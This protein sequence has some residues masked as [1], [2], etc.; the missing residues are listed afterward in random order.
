MLPIEAV[1]TPA[2]TTAPKASSTTSRGGAVVDP[3][4]AFPVFAAS[5]SRT[6]LPPVNLA[7]VRRLNSQASLQAAGREQLQ[8]EQALAK[9]SEEDNVIRLLRETLRISDGGSSD[10]KAASGGAAAAND[11]SSSST[12]TVGQLGQDLTVTLLPY[13]L[14][15]VKWM[16]DNESSATAIKG[17]I[18]ADDMGLGKTIQV[19][20]L[21]LAHRTARRKPMLVVCM[22]STLNQWLDEITTRIAKRKAAR[23]LTYYGSGR[24][25]SKELVES[26]DIVLTTYGTLAAEFKGKGTDAKAKTAAK[27]SLLASIHWWR[28]VLDEAHLIKNKKTKTAM[29]AHQLQAEQRWCLSGTPIQNSL[30][31]LYSLLCFL[32]VPVVSDLDWWNTYIVKPSKAKATSTRE[33]ARRRLQLILQSLLLR[34]TKDQSYN[35][36]PILQLPTK[37]I[38]LRATT[39]SAD[40][41]I[42][43]DDLFN[44]AKN[45]FNKY[46]RDGTVLNNYMKV[47]ELLLRLRQACDHPALALKGKAAAPS[48]E[49]D[50][51]PICVQPLEEDAVVASKCRHRFCADC[52]ASQLA[53]GE[54]RCPTCD[55]AID[56]D[57]LLP[58]SSSPKLNGR[59]RPVA[60]EAEEHSSA[61]IEALMKALTKVREE[62]P[63]EKSIVFSQFTSFLDLVQKHMKRH[64]I[65]FVRLDGSMVQNH[66]MQAIERFNTD[67]R[68]SVMLISLKAGGTGLNL[69]VANHVFLLD[70][71]W[72][73][74]T[75]VQAIDRV[76]RLGQT[77]PVSVTQFVIKDSVEEKIIKMQ[78]RKKALAADVLSSDTN[79]KASLSRLSVSELRHLFPETHR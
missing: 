7:E 40:E 39:F 13:Q 14:D 57:K 21:Y 61:K 65:S 16:V 26:Y 64:N 38:T 67:P 56:S 73:P 58:L 46:A 6:K 62:R 66:R 35:G 72:N 28:V 43:Y 10:A 11:Q 70:P 23:V 74:F 49:E 19:I 53:S 22:L 41:R 29:A 77:R 47:L 5:T 60:E 15:G 2:T 32:H 63:G 42:V 55:V 59:E 50:V 78:E 54:S 68:V 1:T 79:K 75:E 45:T 37:T 9:E 30:D 36:R 76:H 27:P 8:R 51:C 71:W 33:K 12:T 17:G 24:S 4:F 25:Q 52:I 3:S 48:G 18:L 31:D 69:T 44:K 20:A 34:R